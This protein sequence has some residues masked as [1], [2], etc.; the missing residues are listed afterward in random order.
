[1]QEI[2]ARL[3]ETYERNQYEEQ[4]KYFLQLGYFYLLEKQYVYA[5]ACYNFAL[6]LCQ[7]DKKTTNFRIEKHVD[8]IEENINKAAN[9]FLKFSGYGNKGISFFSLAKT[10]KDDLKNIR[11]FAQECLDQGL[12]INDAYREINKK[13]RSFLENLIERCIK[14][15]GQPPCKYA[16]VALGSLGRNEATPYSDLEFMVLLQDER[17]E[18]KKYFRDLTNLLNIQIINLG[19]TTPRIQNITELHW[20]LDRFSD[21]PTVNGFSF[22]GQMKGGCHTPLGNVHLKLP[23]EETFELIHAPAQMSKFFDE[24]SYI[25]DKHFSTAL[26]TF[27]W[28]AGDKDLVLRY[29]EEVNKIIHLELA[30]SSKSSEIKHDTFAKRNSLRLLAETIEKFWPKMGLHEAEIHYFDA[31][32]DLYR[33]PNMIIDQLVSYF[34]VSGNDVWTR[35]EGL[36]EIGIFCPEGAHNISR[37]CSKIASIRLNTC[38]K[39]KSKDNRLILKKENYTFD[40]S[41]YFTISI[42]EVIDV[43]KSIIPLYDAAKHFSETKSF[44]LLQR[45]KFDD[46]S[47]LMLGRIHCFLLDFANAEEYFNDLIIVGE[48]R[49][50]VLKENVTNN[51]Q[52][53]VKKERELTVTYSD[54]SDAYEGLSEIYHARGDR[55]KAGEYKLKKAE[56]LDSEDYNSLLLS[57]AS[58]ED[59]IKKTQA[60][61]IGHKI[62]NLQKKIVEKSDTKESIGMELDALEKLF[63]KIRDVGYLIALSILFDFN[64]NRQKYLEISKKAYEM[65]SVRHSEVSKESLKLA[66]DIADAYSSEAFDITNKAWS[67]MKQSGLQFSDSTEDVQ[68]KIL[69]DKSL[70]DKIENLKRKEL[71]YGSNHIECAKPALSIGINLHSQKKLEMALHYLRKAHAIFDYFHVEDS[72]DLMLCRME[73]DAV[74]LEMQDKQLN[75]DMFINAVKKGNIES[76]QYYLSRGVDVNTRDNSELKLTALHFAVNLGS[77]KLVEFLLAKGADPAIK[78]SLGETVV[79]WARKNECSDILQLIEERKNYRDSKK[80]FSSKKITFNIKVDAF[81]VLPNGKIVAALN[82]SLKIIDIDNEGYTKILN[83]NTG[84]LTGLIVFNGLIASSSASGILKIWDTDLEKCIKIVDTH[85]AVSALVGYQQWVVSGSEDKAIRIWDIE[86]EECV[87]ILEGHEDSINVVV[88]LESFHQLISGSQDTTIRIWDVNQRTCVASLSG[89]EKGVTALGVLPNGQI[90]SGSRDNT[91]KIWDIKKRECIATLEGHWSYITKIIILPN[92]QIVS[93]SDDTTL[94]IWDIDKKECVATLEGHENGIT[95]LGMLPGGRL[96]SAA[97]KFLKI[98]NFLEKNKITSDLERI[99]DARKHA[100]LL[101]IDQKD[102]THQFYT[103]QTSGSRYML[104]IPKEEQDIQIVIWRSLNDLS[105]KE[106]KV[107]KLFGLAPYDVQYKVGN[108]LFE[109]IRISD[110]RFS[111][112]EEVRNTTILCLR[113]DFELQERLQVIISQDEDKLRLYDGSLVNF[114]TPEEYIRYMSN[115]KTWGTYLE[116]VA[117]S[118]ALQR[119]IIIFSQTFDY[120]HIVELDNYRSN[121]PI[122]IQRIEEHYCPM[123]VP[124]GRSA[125]EILGEIRSHIQNRRV[126]NFSE[127]T[128]TRTTLEETLVAFQAQE[129]KRFKSQFS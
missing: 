95:T 33:L 115:D 124:A 45:L 103:Y 75:I 85:A 97:N 126:E 31:K 51:L 55:S 5:I 4:I 102:M 8:L 50:S 37:T 88:A 68:V 92:G 74:E 58:E 7:N 89:H 120:P 10:D 128:Q 39:N 100:L 108:C 87:A 78:N 65:N 20:L 43:Y 119:P 96:I 52:E 117:L 71:Q 70:L 101:Q 23:P 113:E 67:K 64:G 66:D 25:K 111:S 60:H 26:G 99:E 80:L 90:V 116:V 127:I 86:K 73:L 49:I 77:I 56:I 61:L 19:E 34:N 57:F 2:L 48:E 6:G 15:L 36:L 82:D 44:N 3:K 13:I 21:T 123:A 46:S 72:I 91:L 24:E 53:K 121:E 18:Y 93:G 27:K 122:F 118:R 42:A 79:E 84:L 105:A 106:I 29:K 35:I 114:H 32:Y 129:I 11:K 30:S 17:E 104:S 107:D 12:P 109:A 125:V 110:H 9:D 69:L 16:I 40:V 59:R 62:F 22:D 38:L 41:K 83:G 54:M 76:V 112:V 81:V 28:I 1:M 63:Y 47:K 98:W 94:K 14:I